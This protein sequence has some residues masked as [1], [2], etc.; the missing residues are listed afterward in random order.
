MALWVSVSSSC[1]V[2][3]PSEEKIHELCLKLK[4]A[5]RDESEPLLNELKAALHE[6]FNAARYKVAAFALSDAA[7]DK[8]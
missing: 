1:D 4:T 7:R 8:S 5:S 2:P 3:S 6:H